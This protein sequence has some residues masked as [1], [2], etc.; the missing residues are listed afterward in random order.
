M[1]GVGCKGRGGETVKLLTNMCKVFYG[2]LHTNGEIAQVLYR[3]SSYSYTICKWLLFSL[4]RQ[5]TRC[6][7]NYEMFTKI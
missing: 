5:P 7:N 1:C 6:L 2:A 4:W 3:Y